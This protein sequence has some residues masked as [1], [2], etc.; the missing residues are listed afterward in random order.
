[1]LGQ[2]AEADAPGQRAELTRLS[3]R[4]VLA[5]ADIARWRQLIADTGA[6]AR[7]EQMITE[8]VAA[9]RGLLVGSALP[10]FVRE[11]LSDL[12][13]LYTDRTR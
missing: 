4:A 1:M 7:I 3:R 11:T 9:A 6:T 12:A 8:R 10:R 5:E 2:C 13:V